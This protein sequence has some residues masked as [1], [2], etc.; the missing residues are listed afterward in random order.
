MRAF[1][2]TVSGQLRLARFVLFWTSHL[3]DLRD[4]R[5]SSSQHLWWFGGA[6]TWMTIS[7]ELCWCMGSSD[8]KRTRETPYE[9]AR[10]DGERLL[11]AYLP[12]SALGRPMR[13]CIGAG[14]R[15]TGVPLFFFLSE[16]PRQETPETR[17]PLHRSMG[18]QP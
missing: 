1:L 18:S 9:L 13:K 5:I 6:L 12:K 10:S 4:S 14:G 8:L 11:R 15:T 2:L 7:Q 3:H 16:A 17:N